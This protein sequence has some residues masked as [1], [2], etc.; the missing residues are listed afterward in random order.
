MCTE[1]SKFQ[2]F[3]NENYV[4]SCLKGKTPNASLGGFCVEKLPKDFELPTRDI[5]IEDGEIHLIRFIRSDRVL[6]VFG[7]K[8]LLNKDLVYEYVTAT[9][10]TNIHQLQIRHEKKTGSMV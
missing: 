6:D 5:P 4:Y 3:H 7:E 9:I 2:E 10:C 8:F 1:L